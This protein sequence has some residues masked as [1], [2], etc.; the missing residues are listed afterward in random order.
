MA[1]LG[2]AIV[3][4][5]ASGIGRAVAQ[6]LLAEGT[7]VLAV[8]RREP[9]LDG[10][11][12]HVC[13]LTIAA[14]RALLVEAA[15]DVDYLVNAAGVIHI[16]PLD[17]ATEDQWERTMAVNAKAIFFLLQALVPRMRAGSAVV[18]IASTAGKTA[19]TT[20]AAIYN[21]SKAAVIAITKTF[22]HAYASRGVRV[23]C[24]CPAPTETPMLTALAAAI[25]DARSTT[26][27]EVIASYERTIPLGRTTTPKEVA[28]VIAFLLSDE[29]SYMTG[30]A[31]NVSGGL[32]TY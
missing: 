19:S 24:V 31:V 16:A 10:A 1:W 6:R 11:D 8:D 3:T 21:A 28:G 18:N 22:A 12:A 27:E 20:E 5:A 17:Q 30:Q 9:A 7:R 29:A 13:D 2:S 32:V 14:E 23:N 26:P 25:A 4:G 15:G